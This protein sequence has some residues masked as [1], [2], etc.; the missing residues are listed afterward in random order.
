MRKI[1]HGSAR[2]LSAQAALTTG[3]GHSGRSPWRACLVAA[4]LGLAPSV[5]LADMVR[6]RDGR[7]LEGTIVSQD[8]SAISLRTGG[9]V[10]RI[11]KTLVLR[12]QYGSGA[13]ARRARAKA[14][15]KTEP[16][17]S[18]KAP[19]RTVAAK[20]STQKRDLWRP[21]WR[22]ALVP[23][24]GLFADS[25]TEGIAWTTITLS[26]LS[27]ALGAQQTALQG[28]RRYRRDVALAGTTA[29]LLPG[30]QQTQV[31]LALFLQ[32]GKLSTYRNKVRT[33]NRIAGLAGAFY[34]LQLARTG[35]TAGVLVSDSTGENRWTIA[36]HCSRFIF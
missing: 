14:E 6:L 36:F 15:T 13:P 12:I 2:P 34:V 30:S 10:Q 20:Q 22:S 4:L 7:S 35:W 11:P 27:A 33:Y 18:K 24:W 26:V 5:V 25:R 8:R 23:G 3:Q 16:R 19:A 1:L 17:S 31:A 29:A 28:G 21:L 9:R 32:G